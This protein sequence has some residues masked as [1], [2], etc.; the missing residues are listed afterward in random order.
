M[1]LSFKA[2]WTGLL[3]LLA[4]PLAFFLP[5]LAGASLSTIERYGS[6]LAERKRLAVVSIAAVAIVLRLSA[7]PWLPV[8]VSEIHDEFSYLLSGDTFAHGRL[9]NPPHPMWLYFETFH[10]IQQ[11]TYMSKY[12]P[13]QGLV[14]ALGQILGHPWIGV[15]LSVAA[16]CAVCLWALQG[17]L[18]PRWALLGSI[19]VLFRFAIFGYWINS[20]W[21]GAV[22]AI[23]GALV[24]G[25]LPRIIRF[26]RLRDPFILGIGAA[27]LLNSRPFEGLIFCLPVAGSLLLW[28]FRAGH[29][30]WKESLQRTVLP[31][32]AV[33]VLCLAFDAFYNWRGTGNPLLMPYSAYDH[34]YCNLPAFTWQK[35]GPSVHYLNPQFAAFYDPGGWAYTTW[36]EGRIH[37]ARQF[38]SRLA[39][40]TKFFI[41]FFLWPELCV[42]PLLALFW[43]LRD[44]KVRFLLIEITVC[45]SSSL[46]VVWFQPHYAAALTAT[47]FILVIQGMRHLRLWQYHGRPI[48]IAF[49]RLVV[50]LAVVLAPFHQ[51]YTNLVPL[52]TARAQIARQLYAMPGKHLVI[53]RYSA[54]HDPQ[55]EWVHNESDIDHAKV[56]WAREIPGAALDPLLSYFYGR[57]VWLLEADADEPAL[58]PY[59]SEAHKSRR[60]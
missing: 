51:L 37:S 46:L 12:P 35:P 56:V 54:N 42:A 14:L 43:I 28:L 50:I 2:I 45:L 39:F 23:G 17:W 5:R 13:A 8:T 27:V 59:A 31:L 38:A 60:K 57:Q 11:P 48:G 55:E 36:C 4:F 29:P 33:S 16:M 34:T 1:S 19:L 15:L 52:M 25:A 26:G 32:C 18:P 10:V 6:R 40:N 30:T 53:V 49:T 21:G 41:S 9:S 58:T 24:I 22:A 47:T 20:Y 7:L 3:V 44:R